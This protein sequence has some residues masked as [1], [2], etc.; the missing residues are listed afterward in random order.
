MIVY[1]FTD[2]DN[3]CRGYQYAPG[4][5]HEFTG[6]GSLCS[7]GWSHAYVHP[8]LAV[9]H[10]PIHGQY[11]PGGVLWRCD[12]GDGVVLH[13]GK[14]KLGTSKITLVE[15]VDIPE[16]PT[17][18]R[19]EYGIRSA[20]CIVTSERWKSWARGWLDGTDRTTGAAAWAWAEAAWA[21]AEAA[22]AA[23]EAAEAAWAWAE[24][25]RAEEMT[26]EAR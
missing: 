21:W 18:Q 5:V 24:A 11:L 23:R 14:M 3:R 6:V 25:A 8:L 1:K 22:E 12:T 10:D 13:D 2:T 16:I 15:L 20:L 26:A 9:L 7:P 19:V 17:L 4:K